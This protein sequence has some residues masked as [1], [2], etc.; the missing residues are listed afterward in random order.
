MLSQ[1]AA[2]RAEQREAHDADDNAAAY[3]HCGGGDEGL[4]LQVK[5][6]IEKK[7]SVDVD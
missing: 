4:M 7:I 2:R 1:I 6:K 5:K 3:C